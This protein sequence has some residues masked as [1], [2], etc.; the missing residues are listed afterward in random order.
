MLNF[1]QLVSQIELF[2]QLKDVNNDDKSTNTN[3]DTEKADYGILKYQMMYLP[4]KAKLQEMA[5]M[6]QLEQRLG[7][8]EN[9]LGTNSQKLTTFPQVKIQILN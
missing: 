3:R 6:G 1:R 2:K 5:R 7:H 8:L 4:E 9:I